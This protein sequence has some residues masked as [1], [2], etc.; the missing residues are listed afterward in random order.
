MKGMEVSV[1]Y[2]RAGYA[3]TD[4]PTQAEYVFDFDAP[5]THPPRPSPLLIN[6]LCFSLFHHLCLHSPSLRWDARL[7]L[8]RSAAVKCPTA[9]YQV[10]IHV[11]LCCP[12]LSSFPRPFLCRSEE[13]PA[14]YQQRR[15]LLADHLSGMKH[16]LQGQEG[17]DSMTYQGSTRWA[18]EVSSLTERRRRRLRTRAGDVDLEEE[19]TEDAARY[20]LKPQREGGGNNFYDEVRS[21]VSGRM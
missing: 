10:N 16:S 15:V 2:F 11:L 12:L 17:V 9:A 3:P 8:E 19:E 18:M 20:V 13:D 6:T 1:V 7:L 14:G 21:S 4:F 5:C